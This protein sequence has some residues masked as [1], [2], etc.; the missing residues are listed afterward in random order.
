MR[1]S[2]AAPLT[3]RSAAWRVLFLAMAWLWA[4]AVVAVIYGHHVDRPNGPWAVVDGRTLYT[5]YPAQTLAQG[6]HVGAEIMTVALALAVA[7]GTVDLAVRL[8]RRMT[9]PGVAALSAGGMLVLFSLFGLL[10][11]LAGLGTA[12]LLVVLSGLSMRS[13]AET[14]PDGSAAPVPPPSWYPDPSAA[15]TWRY[16]DGRGWTAHTAPVADRD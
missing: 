7:V 11:G 12:G 13:T 3:R 6:D 10:W 9:V 4:G 16:W 8:V 1:R 15:S 5:H 14:V 2:A